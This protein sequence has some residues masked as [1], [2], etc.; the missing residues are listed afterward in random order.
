VNECF[1]RRPDELVQRLLDTTLGM[2]LI[3]LTAFERLTPERQIALFTRAAAACRQRSLSGYRAGAFVIGS[4]VNPGAPV[5][6]WRSLDP[7]TIAFVMSEWL[8]HQKYLGVLDV[9]GEK[10]IGRAK[11]A[12]LHGALSAVSAEAAAAAFVG[13]TLS[14][15][16]LS[17]VTLAIPDGSDPQTAA[18]LNLMKRAH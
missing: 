9:V 5:A 7:S 18:I 8:Q 17:A 4:F 3:N 2:H 14:G 11:E 6:F 13:L 10:K 1:D 16:D 12:I 15:V